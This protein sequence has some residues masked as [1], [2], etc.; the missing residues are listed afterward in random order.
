M[1]KVL[2][3]G[4][5]DGLHPGHLDFLESAAKLGD[6]LVVSV[7]QD[8]IVERLKRRPAVRDLETRMID[9]ALLPMVTEVMAGD[10]EIG[11]YHGLQR[12]KPD[13]IALGYDQT[14]LGRDLQRFQQATGDETRVVVLK[15]YQP[16]TYKSSL[17]RGPQLV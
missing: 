11:T 15:P 4:T 14:E 5:F 13:L 17:L 1:T 6:S 8:A 16:E 12:V 7:A 3:F 9:L 10:L 2:V